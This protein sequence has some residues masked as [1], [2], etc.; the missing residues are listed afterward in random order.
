MKVAKRQAMDRSS[1][2]DI[3]NE[4]GRWKTVPQSK[5]SKAGP[6][7]VMPIGIIA[8]SAN[9]WISP[10]TFDRQ[11]GSIFLQFYLLLVLVNLE[12]IILF[13]EKNEIYV[14]SH[15]VTS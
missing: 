10:A 4:R 14:Y 8:S 2:V 7:L 1:S 13:K 12:I 11:Q 15:S 9:F 6:F 5:K 3:Q